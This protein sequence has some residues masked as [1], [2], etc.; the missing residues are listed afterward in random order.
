MY[1]VAAIQLL[2]HNLFVILIIS[3]CG[4]DTPIVGVVMGVAMGVA[5]MAKFACYVHTP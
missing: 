4:H 5:S 1:H 3:G 2:H